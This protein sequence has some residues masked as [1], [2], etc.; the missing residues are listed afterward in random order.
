[1]EVQLDFLEQLREAAELNEFKLKNRIVEINE[2]IKE[3]R[4]GKSDQEGLATDPSA[5]DH[6]FLNPHL[7]TLSPAAS[8]AQSIFNPS[9]KRGDMLQGDEYFDYVSNNFDGFI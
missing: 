6:S 8:N 9:K 1:M 5:I 4:E 2:E 7:P 3:L